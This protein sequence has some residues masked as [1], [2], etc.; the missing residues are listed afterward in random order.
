MPWLA[1]RSDAHLVP[2]RRLPP[3]RLS[4]TAFRTHSWDGVARPRCTHLDQLTTYLSTTK[5]WKAESA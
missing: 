4:M 5:G 2:R 1:I 3:T